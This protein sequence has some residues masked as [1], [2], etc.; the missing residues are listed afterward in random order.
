MNRLYSQGRI[1]SLPVM[2]A[3]LCLLVLTACDRVNS[4]GTSGSKTES[5]TVSGS[6]SYRE[7]MALSPESVLEVQLVD[8]SRVDAMAIVIA[9]KSII[10]PGQVPISFELAYDPA[11]IDERFTYAV[12]ARISEGDRLVFINDMHTPVLTGGYG[13]HVEMVLVHVP[14][15]LPE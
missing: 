12:Q 9:K 5:L 1:L 2:M 6:I 15:H 8:V 4:S 10:G 11:S 13:D 7:R 3:L 14:A